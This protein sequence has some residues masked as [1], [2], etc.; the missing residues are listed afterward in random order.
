[1]DQLGE[2]VTGDEPKRSDEREVI[3]GD[4]D[5]EPWRVVFGKSWSSCEVYSGGLHA[6]ARN[7]QGYH[8]DLMKTGSNR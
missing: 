5:V 2:G 4:A 8:T 3:T 1:M 7:H 6:T